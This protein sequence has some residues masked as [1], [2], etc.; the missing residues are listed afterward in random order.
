MD[1]VT[2]SWWEKPVDIADGLQL[3]Q[4][5]LVNT[6]LRDCSQNYTA[7]MMSLKTKNLAKPWFKRRG[8]RSWS[9][10]LVSM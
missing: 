10:E 9:R 7:G 3:P 4:F 2:F 6:T 1:I 8:E 5:E